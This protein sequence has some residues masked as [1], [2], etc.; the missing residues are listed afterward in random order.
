MISGAFYTR[1]SITSA[2]A[3]EEKANQL[4]GL[5]LGKL[6]RQAAMH[7]W[8]P[9]MY[10]EDYISVAHLRDDVLREDWSATRR[11]KLWEKVQ[12][13]VENNSNVRSM[14][15]E[16]RSGDVGRVW[17]WVGAVEMIENGSSPAD[18][19]GYID[20][21][22]SGHQPRVSFGGF[23]ERLIEPR[24]RPELNVLEKWEEPR[25]YY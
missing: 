14:V 7:R 1:H 18:S 5:A 3:T 12:R 17:E 2:K 20:R 24:D 22:R 19:S 23:E 6:N 25:Q 9:D 4:A 16:G 13:K 11:K 21:R 10:R 15:K 8:D